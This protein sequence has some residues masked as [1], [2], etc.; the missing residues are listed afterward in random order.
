MR[1]WAR[2]PSGIFT[3]STPA[4]FNNRIESS[5]FWASTP[6]GGR[7]STE[8][9]NSP[10]TIFRDQCERSAGGTSLRS[11]GAASVI[12]AKAPDV[13]TTFCARGDAARTASEINLMWAGVVPQQP[14]INFAPAW[15][16]RLA[17]F[18][19]YSGEHM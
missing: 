9:T 5:V 1:D 6:L 4:S 15:I 12:W 14:P 2:A 18:D 7:T 17:N 10:L 8:V 16:K 3:P 19:M 11:G 13:S